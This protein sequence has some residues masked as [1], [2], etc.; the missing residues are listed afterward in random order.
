VQVTV[1]PP[2]LQPPPLPPFP[3]APQSTTMTLPGGGQLVGMVDLPKGMTDDSQVNFNLMLQLGPFLGATECLVKVL[4]LCAWI[5]EFVQDVPD[6]VTRPDKLIGKLADLPPIADDVLKCVTDWSP[7]GI[8][9]F[10]K[11]ILTMISSFVGPIIDLLQGILQQQM[12]LQT[13]MG[14]AQGNP[15]LLEVLDASQR[16]TEV[17]TQQAM[18]SC[19]PVFTTLKLVEPFLEMVGAGGMNLPSIDN[20]TGG[21]AE[22][23]VTVLSDV[24]SIIDGVIATLPC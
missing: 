3:P 9:S 8:C 7:V 15:A 22:P 17:M 14:Q 23:I 6:V 5:I 19:A 2:Q 21:D 24:K 20:L 10:V 13:K 18:N 11:D 16:C 1:V 4:N 12:D